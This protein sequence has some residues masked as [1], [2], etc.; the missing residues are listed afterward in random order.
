MGIP[1]DL[2]LWLCDHSARLRI[3]KIYVGLCPVDVTVANS[4]G[5]IAE[6]GNGWGV[7]GELEGYGLS[8]D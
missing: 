4:R 1:T 8:S 3:C 7:K 6:T 2:L 5:W